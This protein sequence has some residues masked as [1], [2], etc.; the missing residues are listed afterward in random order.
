M[1]RRGRYLGARV[2]GDVFA[3]ERQH[4]EQARVLIAL[5]FGTANQRLALPPDASGGWLLL[6]T[7]LDR[8]LVVVSTQIELR[9]AEGVILQH[10]GDR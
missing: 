6:S 9:P 7:E 4:S 10:L 3:F 2:E 8:E 5:N 1:W